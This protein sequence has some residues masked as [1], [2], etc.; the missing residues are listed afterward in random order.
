MPLMSRA[1][2]IPQTRKSFSA[3]FAAT[4]AAT[5]DRDDSP[6][7]SPDVNLNVRMALTKSYSSHN[8]ESESYI[9]YSTLRA[10]HLHNPLESKRFK[11]LEYPV[12][13]KLNPFEKKRILVTG[14]A[15]FVGS[16]LVD[17]LMLSGKGIS[18]CLEFIFLT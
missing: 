1:I 7:V 5:D 13:K 10:L 6:L 18:I 14:G 17:R 2:E 3:T 12:V 4:Y 11:S 9:P 16:H 8:E 15:G